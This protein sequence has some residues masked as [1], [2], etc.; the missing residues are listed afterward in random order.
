M[1]EDAAGIVES[2]STFLPSIKRLKTVPEGEISKI[3]S[4]LRYLYVPEVRGSTRRRLRLPTGS[5]EGDHHNKLFSTAIYTKR[6]AVETVRSDPFERAYVIQWLTRLISFGSENISESPVN[7][8]G[9]LEDAASLLA[10]CA[11]TAASGAFIRTFEFPIDTMGDIN[12]TSPGHDGPEKV[13]VTLRDAPLESFDPSS[14]GAQTWGGSCVLA[15]MIA[16]RPQDF[17]IFPRK[18]SIGADSS[19]GQ[20]TFRALELGA[21]TGLASLVLAKVMERIRPC[22]LEVGGQGS[23]YSCRPDVVVATD[24]HPSVIANLQFNYEANFP[25]Q[26]ESDPYF[27]KDPI[28][29]GMNPHVFVLPLDWATI[30][31]S[32]RVS[33][34]VHLPKTQS[35]T[36]YSIPP[37]LDEQFDLIIGADIVYENLHARWLRSCIERFLRKPPRFIQRNTLS[38]LPKPPQTGALFHL[39]IPLRKTHAIESRS[40]EA[41][42]SEHTD[43]LLS[44]QLATNGIAHSIATTELAILFKE[45]ISC[46]AY[47]D[48]EEVEEVIYRYY[49]IGWI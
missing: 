31:S 16:E 4:I 34:Q 40:V 41:V 5:D 1:G 3:L 6:S 32:P 44:R 45:D 20:D 27:Q 21:G 10:V 38:N 14:V 37:P 23:T 43:I 46:D 26:S 42:F 24:F 2:P 19:G 48:I 29:T 12:N 35:E 28:S 13:A 49:R 30:H 11:G 8:V 25:G 17:G 33:C 9:T 39:I 15:E 36:A 18:Q 7:G 47:S 22:S